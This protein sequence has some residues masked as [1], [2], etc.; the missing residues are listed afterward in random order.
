M[1]GILL[2]TRGRHDSVDVYTIVNGV[3]LFGVT[4]LLNAKFCNCRLK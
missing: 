1:K 4:V 2:K 3:V